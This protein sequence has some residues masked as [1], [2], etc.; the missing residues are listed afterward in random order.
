MIIASSCL[1]RW[2]CV[3]RGDSDCEEAT[4][5]GD[6]DCE[7]ST[8]LGDSDCEES[9]RL[10]D[11]ECEGS[12]RLGDS[13]CDGVHE[14]SILS[15]WQWLWGVHE[16]SIFV[17]IQFSVPQENRLKLHIY[18]LHILNHLFISIDAA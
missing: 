8:R 5:L 15:R 12:T 1:S 4:R 14:T 16:T 13:D 11:S 6:S 10:G 9:T 18:M 3:C 2:Q 17:S 7:G